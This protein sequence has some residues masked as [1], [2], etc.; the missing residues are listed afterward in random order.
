MAE[1]KMGNPDKWSYG[2]PTAIT[3]DFVPTLWDKVRNQGK[4]DGPPKKK[5]VENRGLGKL[6]CVFVQCFQW[7]L[8]QS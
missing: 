6:R 3:G 4:V 1:K 2:H 8:V 7:K 5:V